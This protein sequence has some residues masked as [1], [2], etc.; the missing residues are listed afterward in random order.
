VPP[1]LPEH[2]FEQADRLTTTVGLRQTDLRRAISN[3]YYGLFHFAL[4]AAA[5]MVLGAAEQTTPRY[6]LVYRSVDHAR[7]RALCVQV[8]ATNPQNVA[9]VPVGGFG[10]IADFAR[11]TFNL[12]ELRSLADYDPSRSFTCDEARV[13]ISEA[14]EAIKMFQQGSVEQQQAFLMMLLFKQR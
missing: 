12:Y 14:R 6:A 10:K 4:T 13:A 5:D 8:S 9:L 7:L 1:P 3:A 2:F 11:I